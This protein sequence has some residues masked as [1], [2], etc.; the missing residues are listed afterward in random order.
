MIDIEFEEP[1]TAH[2]E[3][4]GNEST[5]L[6]RF[7]YQDGDAFSIYYVLFT[8]NHPE[9]V[10][11]AIIGLGDWD[12]GAGPESRTAFPVKIWENGDGW[13]VTLTNKNESPWADVKLLGRIL[14]REE[15]LQH[16]SITDVYHIAD[17][18]LAEDRPVRE[19]FK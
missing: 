11:Y 9:K 6:T 14:D 15:A 7:V 18:I 13:A 12:E 8:E 5:S 19:F 16:A 10:A 3:C 17:H 2:C 1:K 4:C